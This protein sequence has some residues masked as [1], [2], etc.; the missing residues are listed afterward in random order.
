MI[1]MLQLACTCVVLSSS[2]AYA[3]D[4]A[5][6]AAAEP[7]DS[8]TLN[9]VTTYS[10][11]SGKI[12]MSSIANPKPSFLP[13]GTYVNESG[14]VLV[15]LEGAITR[16]ERA[17]G[18]ATEIFSVHLGR[19]RVVMLVP[20]TNALMQVADVRLPSGTFRSVDGLSSMRV[21]SGHP[22]SFTIPGS[23]THQ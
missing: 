7:V 8:A 16:L 10:I 14:T 19:D 4:P 11:K 13:D 23:A 3:Q 2:A 12:A 9:G 20:S 15:I 5:P 22:V 17:E 21:L 6:S 18:E 1:R